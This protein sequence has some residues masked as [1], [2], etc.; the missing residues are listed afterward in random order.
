MLLT[1]II[2]GQHFIKLFGITDDLLKLA[3]DRIVIFCLGI[4][5]IGV[6][7]TMSA[8]YQA[9]NRN[10]EA[11]IISI[12]RSFVLQI[13]FSLILPIYMGVE[14]IFYAQAYSDISSIF[15]LGAVIIYSVVKH[16]KQ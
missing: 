6:I 8:Y 9:I 15:I 4:P 16:R 7:Y 2:Y 11:N 3:Y 10:L 13:A 5:V 14:G 1:L 12:G